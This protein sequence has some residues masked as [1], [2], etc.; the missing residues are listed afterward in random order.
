M[1]RHEHFTKFVVVWKCLQMIDL[2]SLLW[3]KYDIG[4]NRGVVGDIDIEI[5]S[6]PFFPYKHM[7]E[8]NILYQIPMLSD[9]KVK[10]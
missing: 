9:G 10:K 6:R 7:G 3:S 1:L 5:S 4:R 2:T 8:K